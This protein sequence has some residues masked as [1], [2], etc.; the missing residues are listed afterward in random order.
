MHVLSP[1]VP[2]AGGRQLLDYLFKAGVQTQAA[3]PRALGLSQPSVARLLQGFAQSDLVRLSARAPEGRGNPSVDVQLNADHAFA[4]GISLMGDALAMALL[5]LT[6]TVRAQ[7]RAPMPSMR[8]ECVL[9]QMRTFAEE[10]LADAGV[11]RKRLLGAGVGISA[12]FSGQGGQMVGPPALEDWTGVE[13]VPIFSDALGM[14][15]LIENDGA[16]AAVAESLQGVGRD[17]ADFIYLHLTNGFGGGIISGGRLLRGYRGNAGEFVGIWTVSGL[18][19]PNLDALLACARAAGSDVAT[20]E[21]LLSDISVTTPGVEDWLAL[22]QEP[23]ARL[24]SILAYSL[25]PQMLVIGGRLPTSLT[26]AL[27]ARLQI[28]RAPNRHG[29]A[30]PLPEL[31]ATRVQGDAVMLGAG[32]LPLQ[33][34][35]FV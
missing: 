29:L 35:F 11:A 27:V 26:A 10:L 28:P 13:L 19:Y 1:A 4:F 9:A 8:R 17:C 33:R 16:T 14:P 21:Q 24:C 30:P 22:A 5:D 32:L 6:G 3:L 7:R 34:A 25:D 15:V 18:A 23:F 20:V 2:S 12:F 31:R